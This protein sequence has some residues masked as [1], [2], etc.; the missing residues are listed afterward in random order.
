MERKSMKI[1][2]IFF[3]FLFLLLSVAS[4]AQDYSIEISNSVGE[5]RV[6][7]NSPS[8]M[9]S[10]SFIDFYFSPTSLPSN[11]EYHPFVII[12]QFPDEVTLTQTLATGNF[13]TLYPAP[14]D[15]EVKNLPVCQFSSGPSL[16]NIREDAVQLL[17][18]VKGENKILIRITQSPETW[19]IDTAYKP[20]VRI[21]VPGNYWPTS[22]YTSNWAENNIDKK[23]P[24]TSF[25]L[26]LRDYNFSNNN[27]FLNVKLGY[28]Y[29]DD[30]ISFTY[31]VL[32]DPVSV[33]SIFYA[34][35]L[36]MS[37]YF[38]ELFV[39]NEIN[40]LEV[41]DVNKDNIPDFVS[42]NSF[43]DVVITYMTEDET[44]ADVKIIH[45]A[46]VPITSLAVGDIDNDGDIEF[47]VTLLSG[48]IL[49]V[50]LEKEKNSGEYLISYKRGSENVVDA[51]LMDVNND[52]NYEYVYIDSTSKTINIMDNNLSL[53]ESYPLSNSPTGINFGDINGDGF[54]DLLVA[55]NGEENLAVLVNNGDSTFSLS[56]YEIN[57]GSTCGNIAVSCG[58]FDRD[59]RDD[60][61]VAQDI[62]QSICSMR[63]DENGNLIP[64]S[65]SFMGFALTP[66]SV[67][68]D[69]FDGENGDDV[70]VGF[71]D[72]YKLLLCTS[73]D[74]GNL[75]AKYS[76]NTIG[77]YIVDPT[78]GVRLSEDSIVN[79]VQG[80]SYG[81]VN[82]RSGVAGLQQRNFN[83]FFFPRS[84]NTSFSFVNLRDD[85]IL[86]NFELFNNIG[87]IK[88]TNT[89]TISPKTQIAL[90]FRDLLGDV[91]NTQGN[92][93]E[94]FSTEKKNF[95]MWLFNEQSNPEY[96]D[97]GPI[98]SA[99]DIKTEAY[100]P[101]V[102]SEDR[103]TKIYLINPVKEENNIILQLYDSFGNLK[104]EKNFIREGHGQAEIDIKNFFN[105]LAEK[106]DY[107]KLYSDK[108][109][110]AFESFG[111]EGKALAVLPEFT[112]SK[113]SNV[114]YVP[115]VACN[116]FGP[117]NYKTEIILLN[118]TDN[119][120]TLSIN[121]FDD[122]G[123]QIDSIPIF[124][125]S[126]HSKRSFDLAD[127]LGLT[128]TT[129]GYIEINSEEEIPLIGAVI[130]GDKDNGEFISSL[131]IVTPT[132]DSYI[133]GHMANGEIG[134]ISYFT[135][136][137]ILNSSDDMRVVKISCFDKN[138]IKLAEKEI[139]LKKKKR[140]V[141]LLSE[142]F[143][144]LTS[145][146]G[147]YII[148]NDESYLDPGITV[149][150]LFGD[151]DLTFLSAV[152]SVGFDQLEIKK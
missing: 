93:S 111:K 30:S 34:T 24:T 14:D 103:F 74:L 54:K 134:G 126:A 138:G 35:A 84:R 52:G 137:A 53:L 105:N 75:E 97:G 40:D 19:N 121:L 16:K 2:I 115:H 69:N 142:I 78:G 150:Q 41:I 33:V 63:F 12:I 85:D 20:F 92:W 144:D 102:Y 22:N 28:Y 51:T 48:E 56:E 112:T 94:A 88:N 17:R 57:S 55:E 152:P 104:M 23:S 148:V 37:S 130:F 132:N 50:S 32:N 81:G 90:F 145:V 47:I 3:F 1:K 73:D 62:S 7:I 113:S 139:T 116:Q 31:Y 44:V 4:I 70:I 71:S 10:N 146:A 83:I 86:L 110:I 60:V 149:F 118:P 96:L 61:V 18:Y 43:G 140:Y 117:V 27:N 5:G 129:T 119:E 79:V 49:K 21:G 120:I 141:R 106:D 42:T 9:L 29:Y 95:G 114:F 89:L 38:N 36:D 133:M 87:N 124:R 64:Q 15:V 25:F 77:D 127:I 99:D 39:G 13:S 45:V 98:L 6:Y 107:I 136:I 68:C 72:Y 58:D 143:P 100:L 65:I 109:V 122:N 80:L 76:I 66:S 8:Q 135:G 59:G 108:G 131:P 128:E 151:D 91:A 82:D 123:S 125:I 11:L 101:A 147:G 26:D 67:L 46:D